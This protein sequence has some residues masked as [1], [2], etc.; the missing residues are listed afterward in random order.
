[1]IIREISRF[2]FIYLLMY[3]FIFYKIEK[4]I[5]SKYWQST[6]AGAVFCRRVFNYL[7]N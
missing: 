7:A 2:Y 1:M 3:L 4:K 5:L 6:L